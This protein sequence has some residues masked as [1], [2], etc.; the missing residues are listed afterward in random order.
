[1]WIYGVVYLHIY[2]KGWIHIGSC[3]CFSLSTKLHLLNSYASI[4]VV[5]YIFFM[6]YLRKDLSK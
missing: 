3:A 5:I 4:K 1:M 2:W 6:F